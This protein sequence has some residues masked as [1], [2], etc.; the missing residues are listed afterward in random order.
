MKQVNH[1]A[2]IITRNESKLYNDQA[3]SFCDQ[4]SNVGRLFYPPFCV[5][6]FMFKTT[7]AAHMNKGFSYTG[8]TLQIEVS[9]SVAYYNPNG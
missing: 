6:I 8:Q 4:Q 9:V 1:V 7:S 2:K 5:S 3:R